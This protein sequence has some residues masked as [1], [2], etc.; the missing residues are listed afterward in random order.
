MA[1]LYYT[2]IYAPLIMKGDKAMKKD[3]E[4]RKIKKGE[5]QIKKDEELTDEELTKAA[6]GVGGMQQLLIGGG[7]DSGRPTGR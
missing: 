1:I 5:T 7:A 4:E 6:G 3:T 2:D